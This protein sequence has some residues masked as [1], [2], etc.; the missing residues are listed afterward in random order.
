MLGYFQT[1]IWFW[2]YPWVETISLLFFDHARLH[3]WLPVS[4]LLMRFAGSVG[5]MGTL[6]D[7]EADADAA[8]EAEARVEAGG[9]LEEI[10]VFQN[11]M[12]RSAVPPP[13]ASRPR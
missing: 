7:P 3:T 12:V 11:L 4:R 10:R 6:A 8:A 5:E 9:P 1:M 2:L 13:L